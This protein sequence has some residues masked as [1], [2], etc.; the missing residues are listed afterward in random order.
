MRNDI[1]TNIFYI[2][3]GIW[4][5]PMN[6]VVG[7]ALLYLGATSWM[8]HAW[9]GKWWIL[10]WSAMYYTFAAIIITGFGLPWW[11]TLPF[12]ALPYAIPKTVDS[13]VTIGVFFTLSLTTLA[14]PAILWV[15]AAF[16]AGFAIRQL[17]FGLDPNDSHSVW[18]FFTALGF[19]LYF[20]T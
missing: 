16:A 2:I 20:V 3:A 10:D 6:P 8:A 17:H 5:M 14:V 12:I 13:F 19:L 4:V 11:L 18:H 15:L 7:V 9:G 1:W